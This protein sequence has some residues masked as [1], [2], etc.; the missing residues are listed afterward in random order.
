MN[1]G[2]DTNFPQSQGGEVELAYAVGGA[3]PPLVGILSSPRAADGIP[4]RG[5]LCA[6]PDGIEL[7]AIGAGRDGGLVA[8][9]HSRAAGPVE[10]DAAFPDLRLTPRAIGD[11]LERPRGA[12]AIL[13]GELLTIA[14]A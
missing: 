8:Q 10:L 4:E 9:V 2:W 5:A 3:D 11:H 13:P 14:L 6:L 12:T 1:N 7:I